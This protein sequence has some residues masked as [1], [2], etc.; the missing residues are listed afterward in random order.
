MGLYTWE[1][2]YWCLYSKHHL[3]APKFYRIWSWAFF[4]RNHT[5]HWRFSRWFDRVDMLWERNAR[6]QMSL[7]LSRKPAWRRHW[8]FL[9]ASRKWRVEAKKD[10]MHIT[11]KS[12]HNL[13]HATCH[14]GTS[15]CG[16]RMVSL[17]RESDLTLFFYE[18][19]VE[20]IRH[21][22][23]YCL[24]PEI[25]GKWYTRKPVADSQEVVNAGDAKESS[26][27]EEDFTKLWCYCRQPTFGTV[28]LC[29][30]ESCN[31]KWFHCDCL[32]IRS[33]PKGKWYCPS[34]HKLPRS[35]KRKR[36]EPCS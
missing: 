4:K 17:K 27:E 9:Y 7:L 18:E 1:V 22:F 6:D 33:P 3:K 19:L 35:N 24:L 31:I 32:R 25:I 8:K 34:C 11:T 28:I 13:Q 12:K 29:D 21:F 2:C 10:L 36:K 14:M 23:I 20:T 16:Q 15:W 26:D 30:N 5:L